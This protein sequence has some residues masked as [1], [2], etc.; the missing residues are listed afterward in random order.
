VALGDRGLPGAVP[1]I[2]N[3]SPIPVDVS[4]SVPDRPSPSIEGMAYFIISECVTNAIKHSLATRLRIDVRQTYGRLHLEVADDGIGGAHAIDG[5]G[6]G[7]RGLIERVAS[8]DGTLTISSPA[9]GPTVI[10]AEL[11]C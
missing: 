1:A 10:R 11:P 4:V 9:G 3:R 7:L 6:T 2:A 5:S 8:V